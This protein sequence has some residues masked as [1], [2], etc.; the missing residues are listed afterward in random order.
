MR[1]IYQR[2]YA[3]DPEKTPRFIIHFVSH[4]SFICIFGLFPLVKM[5]PCNN[6]LAHRLD[7]RQRLLAMVPSHMQSDRTTEI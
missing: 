7:G 2:T 6:D 4:L 1:E 3:E 5:H